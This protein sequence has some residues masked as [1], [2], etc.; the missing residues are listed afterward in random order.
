MEGAEAG[1]SKTRKRKRNSPG[2]SSI[3]KRRKTG[4]PNS[5]KGPNLISENITYSDNLSIFFTNINGLSTQKINRLK[6]LTE[7]DHILCL[8]E[9]NFT[10]NDDNFDQFW[11][12]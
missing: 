11:S 10:E 4:C 7:N 5:E 8:N 9:T 2:I 12:R 6:I 3:A 1:N